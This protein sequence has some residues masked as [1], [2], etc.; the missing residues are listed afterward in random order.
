MENEYVTE[1]ATSPFYDSST[2]SP[3]YRLDDPLQRLLLA[4]FTFLIS[5]LGL[6]GNALVVFAL[7][8][9]RKLQTS[10]NVFVANLAVSDFVT[11]LVLPLH[12]ISLLSEKMPFPDPVCQAIGALTYITIGASI[13]NLALI[14]FN[15]F[16]LITRP[17]V[18]Y[19]KLYSKRNIT[20][21]VVFSWLYITLLVI[22]PPTFGFGALGYSRR[23]RLCTVDN[24]HKFAF[25]FEMFRSMFLQILFLIIVLVLYLLIY[26][27]LKRKSAFNKNVS[28][29]MQ[30]RQ[31]K[32]TKNLFFIVCAYIACV[33]P[34][35]VTCV[36][37]RS[38]VAI[39]WASM[40]TL[41]NSCVNP[42]IYGVN[43]PQ[44]KEVFK[45][46]LTCRL[47]KIAEPSRLTKSLIS[48][49]TTSTILGDK[50]KPRS[51]ISQSEGSRNLQKETDEQGETAD[52]DFSKQMSNNEQ[53]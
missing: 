4:I 46:I 47:R 40:F 30:K 42:F 31:A 53:V 12:S 23:Y 48:L 9:S 51:S 6:P 7:L 14:G 10:T 45:C 1:F 41:V 2:E 52:M 20:A 33:L 19:D 32:V 22:I 39:P 26:L 36:V 13:V 24:S 17:R 8:T 50:Y 28:D 27:F 38:Y 21:M 18:S 44:F 3:I 15:R 16:Y 35:G 5:V 11:C 43:H 34:F 37:P 29:E 25:Y 49:Q